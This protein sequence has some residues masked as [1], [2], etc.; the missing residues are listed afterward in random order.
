MN[1]R[2][3]EQVG[4]QTRALCCRPMKRR[5]TRSWLGNSEI[6]QCVSTVRQERSPRDLFNTDQ[7]YDRP[8]WLLSQH[9]HIHIH[10]EFVPVAASDHNLAAMFLGIH[11]TW[12]AFIARA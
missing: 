5:N 10:I 12:A 2:E 4:T 1:W 3:W 8:H 7:F 11:S 9:E 6:R